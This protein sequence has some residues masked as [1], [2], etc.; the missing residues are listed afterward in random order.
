MF[1]D[2]LLQALSNA[3]CAMQQNIPL[4]PYT[5]WKIGGP[6]RWFWE[7]DAA[8][9]PQVLRYCHEHDIKVWY[10]GRGSNV[11]IDSKGLNGLVI[12]TKKA[13]QKV[14]IKDDILTAEAGLPMP[15]LSKRAARM[16]WGG[17]EYLIGIP[18]SIG[19]GIAIN[20]GLTASGRKEIGDV[21]IDVQ[22]MDKQGNSWW[23]PKEALSLGYRSSNIPERDL[24]VLKARFRATEY[25]SKEEIKHKT[26]EHLAERRRKQPLSK[27]TAGSTFKQPEG[28]KAAGWYI[29]QAGLKGY[30]VGG[31]KVSEKHA[32][33]IENTG[34]SSDNILNLIDYIQLRVFNVF[35]I[36]IIPEIIVI[37]K[38]NGIIQ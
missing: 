12:C 22:L 7:P 27:P 8:L 11:L 19:A 6:T 23:E 3:G 37:K 25:A 36:N 28:G 16:G 26:A 29:E 14:E 10:L 4:A 20:A 5:T 35:D 9:L 31:A 17:Y 18:G 32:N 1:E 21:L 33:W 24:F 38:T 15:A 2:T 13:L 34:Q 30:Q